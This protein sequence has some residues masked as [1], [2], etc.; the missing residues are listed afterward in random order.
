MKLLLLLLLVVL[1]LLLLLFLFPLLLLLPLLL[2]YMWAGSTVVPARQWILNP[3]VSI[4][5]VR[6]YRT[7]E[8]GGEGRR[9]RRRIFTTDFVSAA[10]TR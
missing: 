9:R 2:Q 1:L 7:V 10:A 8:K 4:V 6:T 3:I 5:G